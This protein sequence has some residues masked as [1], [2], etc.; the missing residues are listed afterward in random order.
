MCKYARITA[1]ELGE[2]IGS[3][4]VATERYQPPA[5]SPSKCCFCSALQDF[6]A[7][8]KYET[9]TQRERNGAVGGLA[10][11]KKVPEER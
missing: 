3:Q 9:C 2:S 10:L 5:G 11:G 6:K 1:P 4:D 8:F 7:S